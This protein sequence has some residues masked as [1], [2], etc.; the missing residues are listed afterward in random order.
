MEKIRIRRVLIPIVFLSLL[1]TILPACTTGDKNGNDTGSE[2]T[3]TGGPEETKIEYDEYG[4]EIIKPD[5]PLGLDYGGRDF[6][7]HTRGGV[8]Q[9]EWKADT[10]TGNILNDAIYT[11]NQRVEEQL[12]VNIVVI[13][14]GTWSDYTATTL[15]KM[16]ASIMAGDGSYDLIA[17]FSTPIAT[18]ATTGLIKNLYEVEYI[19]F[20][21]PWWSW[22]IVD[23]LTID[24]VTYFGVGSLS[25]SMIYSMECIYVNTEILEN[26]SPGYN[27]YETVGNGGWTWDEMLRLSDLAY[28]DLNGNGVRDEGDRFGLAFCDNSNTLIGFFYSSG[29]KLTARNSEGYP[30]FKIDIEKALAIVDKMIVMLYE[31]NSAYPADKPIL[32]FSKG[33]IMFYNHWLYWGQ[34][35]YSSLMETYGVVP[36]PKYDA[37]QERYF[38]PVQAG[39]HMYCIPVDAKNI[40]AVGI[41]T[42]ALAAESYRS[43]IPAYYELA[44]K[45][46]YAKDSETSRMVDIMYETVFFDFGYIFNNDLGIMNNITNVIKSKTNTLGSVLKAT[47][48]IYQTK[49]SNLIN[50]ITK[51]R[52]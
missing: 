39:M 9:Y 47:S 52:N 31:T 45:T 29:I 42:E 46:R 7:V 51:V 25:L 14:E 17:G 24:D 28:G 48:N 23:E 35:Q 11:R 3:A 22:S 49:I 20:D 50:E 37:A 18:L 40:E 27:I 33:D 30:E 6:V 2:T 16:R 34:T 12:G 5:I 36:M 8:E 15:P 1:L 43:L 41:I 13:A 32:D 21:K 44:L 4:R 19:D 10:I 26:V 38:T